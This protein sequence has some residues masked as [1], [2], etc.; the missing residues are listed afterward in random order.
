MRVILRNDLIDLKL[1]LV[2]IAFVLL[3]GACSDDAETRLPVFSDADESDDTA[4]TLVPPTPTDP[5]EA[6]RPTLGE[7]EVPCGLADRRAP[8]VAGEAGIDDMSIIIGTGNDRGGLYTGG[9]GRGIPDA[10]EVMAGYC[11]SLGGLAG[12]DVL[13]VEYDAAAVEAADR[14][15]EQCDEVF[16]VVGQG[17]LDAT[18]ATDVRALCALPSYPAWPQGLVAGEPF[19]IHG[20]LLAFFLE[21]AAGQVALVGPRTPGGESR[22]ALRRSALETS[23]V[24][25]VV[26]AEIS[27]PID[28]DPGWDSVALEAFEAGAGLVHVDGSC[29]AVVVPFLRSAEQLGWSPVVLAGPSAYDT[30]CVVGSATEGRGIERLMIEL[31]FLPLEDG[32]VDAPVVTAYARM[33]SELS[34]PVTGDAL[35]ASSAFWRW[36]SAVDHCGSDLSRSCLEDAAALTEAWTAGGLH[37]P[38]DFDGSIDPCV[39]V[40]GVVDGGFIRQLPETPG[41]YDCS[42][43]R[44]VVLR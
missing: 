8:S 41:L 22:R 3:A 15:T 29:E 1:V 4:T 13:V 11:N 10:V 31:P 23:G 16:A 33:L 34:A 27:Y 43:E 35:L 36:A 21:P 14:A 30:E 44:S 9:S 25:F 39:V 19:P 5:P 26:V 38:Y 7:M 32:P 17:Y 20:H 42:P 2:G 18:A 37:R 40:M 28:D 6:L 12:R 24:E